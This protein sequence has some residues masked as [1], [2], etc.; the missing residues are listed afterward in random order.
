IPV[1]NQA[2]IFHRLLRLRGP[3]QA[4]TPGLGLGLYIASEIVTRQGGRIGVESE[5]GKGATFFFTIPSAPEPEPRIDWEE[6]KQ[7]P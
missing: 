5:E 1:E 4:Q 6:H 3:D 7:E 2:L